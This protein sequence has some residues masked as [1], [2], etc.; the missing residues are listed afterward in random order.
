MTT[1]TTLIEGFGTAYGPHRITNTGEDIEHTALDGGKYGIRAF[2]CGRCHK[3]A[4]LAD[5]AHGRVTCTEEGEAGWSRERADALLNDVTFKGATAYAFT[6]P[7]EHGQART[8]TYDRPTAREVLALWLRAGGTFNWHARELRVTC[9][10]AAHSVKPSAEESPA[11]HGR[12]RVGEHVAVGEL[13][14]GDTFVTRCAFT[15][16]AIAEGTFTALGYDG[17]T[18]TQTVPEGTRV[19][20]IH[21]APRPETGFQ[22][23]VPD[24]SSPG[25]AAFH[26][27]VFADPRITDIDIEARYVC[28]YS[29]DGGRT[30][31]KDMHFNPDVC[32]GHV[33][34][35]AASALLSGRLVIAG[36]PVRIIRGSYGTFTRWTIAEEPHQS[37]ERPMKAR[38]ADESE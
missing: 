34:A 35:E 8:D 28:E 19:L 13:G 16:L 11:T 18:I 17:Q 31:F 12:M 30:W 33:Q 29:K 1:P 38:E 24:G 4:V 21:R 3:R 9:F 10:G 5:F 7:N 6:T 37:E 14:P 23:P 25:Y 22:F 15:V 26:A 36:G 2:E 32:G 27:S 20:R